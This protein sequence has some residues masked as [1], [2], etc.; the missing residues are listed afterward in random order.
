MLHQVD[1][2]DTDIAYVAMGS[3]IGDGV[4]QLRR[5]LE[6]MASLAPT[7]FRC[8]SLWQSEPQGL[9]AG[10]NWFT[11]AVVGFAY[12]LHEADLLD[13]LQGIER[14][15]GRPGDHQA[16]TSRTLDLDIVSYGERVVDTP[17]LCLPHPR[18]C[19]RLF[20]LLPLSEIAPEYRLPGR[21]ESIDELIRRAPA[22]AIQRMSE[23]L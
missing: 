18:A 14:S 8:S 10:A 5:A 19:Q 2:V 11:N 20:V 22:M 7:G 21:A 3:N 1:A 9:G 13:A 15:Q 16:N 6:S 17:A 4:G 12:A 23:R